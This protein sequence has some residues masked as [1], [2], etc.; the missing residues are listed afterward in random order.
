MSTSVLLEPIASVQGKIV[1]LN[2]AMVP[3]LDRGYLFADAVY[4]VLRVY[5]GRMFLAEGH[6]RRLERSLA[7]IRINGVDVKGISQRVAKLIE[8][9]GFQE[10]LVYIQISR[11]VAPRNHSF[12][13]GAQPFEF[14][15]VQEFKDYATSLR[16]KGVNVSIQPDIRWGRCDIKSTNLLGNVLAFQNAKEKGGFEAILY[17]E[18]GTVT[19]MTRTSF[20]V[21][22]DGVIWTHPEGPRILP[23]ITRDLVFKLAEKTNQ[24]IRAQAIKKDQLKSCDEMFL[25]GTTSEVIPVVSIDGQ[26]VGSGQPG[27]VTRGMEKAFDEYLQSWLANP[28]ADQSGEFSD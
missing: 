7:A 18:D 19:E 4:E 15:F 22:R 2:Q 24:P 25:A 20:F 28:K 27:P 11:G 1:P 9:K 3:A 17:R 8:E 13:D 10:A 6:F 23:S 21:V 16:E 12:P 5:R 26:P 14:F